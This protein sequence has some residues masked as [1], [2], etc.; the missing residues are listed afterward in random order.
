MRVETP[1]DPVTIRLLTENKEYRGLYEE[2]RMLEGKLEEM[3]QKRLLSP[4]EDL[5]LKQLKKLKLAGKDRMER[6]IYKA[7]EGLDN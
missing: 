2:H 1:N 4:E 7:R 5:E 6:L 3:S